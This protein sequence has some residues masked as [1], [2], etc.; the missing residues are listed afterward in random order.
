MSLT[1]KWIFHLNSHVLVKLGGFFVMRNKSKTQNFVI[2]LFFFLSDLTGRAGS[3]KL[4]V[5]QGYLNFI[6]HG[7]VLATSQVPEG[8]LHLHDSWLPT[9]PCSSLTCRRS[10]ICIELC[11]ECWV[12]EPTL[13]GLAFLR[14]SLGDKCIEHIMVWPCPKAAFVDRKVFIQL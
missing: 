2:N 3:Y 9:L 4:S 14:V 11:I 6:Y 10:F 7:L 13:W 5:G 8:Y 1:W 12:Q